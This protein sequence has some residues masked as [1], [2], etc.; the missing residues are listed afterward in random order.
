MQCIILSEAKQNHGINVAK[1]GFLVNGQ[2]G[3]PTIGLSILEAAFLAA[4]LGGST[5]HRSRNDMLLA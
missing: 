1:M 3:I 4:C 5:A 2:A